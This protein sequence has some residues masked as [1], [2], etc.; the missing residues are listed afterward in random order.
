MWKSEH[1]LPRAIRPEDVMPIMN[2]IFFKAYGNQ[3]NNCK[4]TAESGW[5]PPNRKLL[6]HPSLA[7]MQ[8]ETLLNVE[9]GLAGSILD[10][11]LWERSRSDGAKKAAEKR[12]LTSDTISENIKKSQRL[13]SGILANNA[14]HSLDDPRFLEPFRQ[15]RIEN[16]IKEEDKKTKRKAKASKLLSGVKA[17]RNKYGMDKTHLFATC[18]AKEC[19][20][21]LQ[22]KKLKTDGAMP[23]GLEERR[24]LCK[25]WL[26]RPS[27]TSSPCQSDDEDDGDEGAGTDQNDAV[28]ALLGMA[29]Q[30][31]NYEYDKCGSD[32]RVVKMYLKLL[33]DMIFTHHLFSLLIIVFKT[34]LAESVS[35]MQQNATKFCGEKV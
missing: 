16:D 25:E 32:M 18:N 3:K 12:K 6:E 33:N 22:Y 26:Q 19:A 10:R 20:V 2:R 13:T 30:N 34:V 24:Q 17:I 11:L 14:V 21:Y 27:P 1:G 29:G 4:A 7:P 35:M 9:E 5:F 23:K 28:Q 8:K 15:R 31:N